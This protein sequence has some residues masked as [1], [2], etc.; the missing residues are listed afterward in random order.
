MA[1]PRSCLIERVTGV[2]VQVARYTEGQHFLQHEDA[3]PVEVARK[4]TYQ[5]RATLLIYLND[6]DQG[7]KTHFDILNIGVAVRRGRISAV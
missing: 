5:R 3:F 1:A 7:G 2:G 6:V 4:K